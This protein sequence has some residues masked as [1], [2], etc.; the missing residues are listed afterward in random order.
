MKSLFDRKR[1]TIARFAPTSENP[2]FSLETTVVKLTDF[3]KETI[4]PNQVIK[5]IRL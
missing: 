4:Y 2:H 5:E 3:R 1:V